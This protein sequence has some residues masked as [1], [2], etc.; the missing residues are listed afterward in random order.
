MEVLKVHPGDE[1]ALLGL[2]TAQAATGDLAGARA[3]LQRAAKGRNPG[4][5]AE[6]ME[7]LGKLK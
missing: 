4:V 2:G 3:S 1:G 6:A 5:T 7:L